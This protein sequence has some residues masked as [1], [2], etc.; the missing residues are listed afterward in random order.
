MPSR[1]RRVS[2]LFRR[3]GAE[4][5]LWTDGNAIN[6][7]GTPFGYKRSADLVART[8]RRMCAV[9]DCNEANKGGPIIINRDQRIHLIRRRLVLFP[10]NLYKAWSSESLHQCYI[11]LETGREQRRYA[12]VARLSY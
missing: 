9:L 1:F 10:N 2:A 3:H 8:Y 7:G 5:V 4:E 12:I 6:L 11:T